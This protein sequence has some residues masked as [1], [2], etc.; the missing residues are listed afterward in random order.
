MASPTYA[1][2]RIR[3]NVRENAT[4][5]PQSSTKAFDERRAA[6]REIVEETHVLGGDLALDDLTDWI[7]HHTEETGTLP[8]IPAIKRKARR[9]ADRYDAILPEDSPLRE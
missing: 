4:A 6:Y 2:H 9:I 7:V 5:P 3:R 8:D 1:L